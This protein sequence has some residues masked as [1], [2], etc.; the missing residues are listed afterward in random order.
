MIERRLSLRPIQISPQRTATAAKGGGGPMFL[1]ATL[2]VALLLPTSGAS[3]SAAD[4]PTAGGRSTAAAAPSTPVQQQ[5]Q[6]GFF[7]LPS[8]YRSI[9]DYCN[10]LG[11]PDNSTISE[12]DQAYAGATKMRDYLTTPYQLAGGK[13]VCTP[14]CQVLRRHSQQQH[15]SHIPATQSASCSLDRRRAQQRQEGPMMSWRAAGSNVCLCL[16]FF[17]S[18]RFS[19]T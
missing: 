14:G 12:F 16:L 9:Q 4:A 3:D 10:R 6:P 2:A 17:S 8:G 1:A 5:Q 11:K 15:S 19:L 13:A 18:R 7:V